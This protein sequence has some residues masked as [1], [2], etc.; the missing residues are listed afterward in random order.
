MKTNQKKLSQILALFLLLITGYK[1][2]VTQANAQS[3]LGLSAIPPRL[4]ISLNP[5][6]VVTREIKVRNESSTERVITTIT[7]DFIVNTDDGTPVR[8]ATDETQNRWAASNWVQVS[9]SQIKLKPGET[10]SLM[11]SVLAPDDAIPGGHY[12][13]VLHSPQNEAVLDATGSS[14][15]TNVGTLVYITIAGDIKQDAQITDF[16]APIFLEYGPVDFTTTIKNLSD[17]HINPIGHIAIS[18]IFGKNVINLPLNNTN[19]FPYTSRTFENTFSKKWLFGR[20]KANL[21]AGYGTAGGLLAATIFFWV[22]PWKII[23]LVVATLALLLILIKL[24]GQ[25]NPP[26]KDAQKVEKLEEE[27]SELK[28]KYK[29]SK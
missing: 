21:Q 8:V 6:E 4:E 13:M 9:P 25:T 24:I 14:I 2:Q 18:N 19:I 15:E 17:I 11:L 23:V 1:L 22:I 16:S 3:A 10:K 27:L 7:S 29:D 28:K 12:A 26:K 5:G 20:Y